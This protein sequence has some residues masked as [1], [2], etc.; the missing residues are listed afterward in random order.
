MTVK[1]LSRPGRRCGEGR[2]KVDRA[3]FG[4]LKAFAIGIVQATFFTGE[5]SNFCFRESCL[6]LA[7]DLMTSKTSVFLDGL[8]PRHMLV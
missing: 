4:S 6:E 2:A 8:Q 3:G 1:T 5:M 7:A